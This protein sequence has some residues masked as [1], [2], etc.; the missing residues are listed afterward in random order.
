MEY[1]LCKKRVDYGVYF[2]IISTIITFFILIKYLSNN[3]YLF[4]ILAIALTILDEFDN[5]FL[6]TYKNNICSKSFYYQINDKMVDL[7]SYWLVFLFFCS[8][9]FF[10]V[11]LIYRT[12]GVLLFAFTKNSIWLI[13][14]PDILKEYLVYMF[15]YGSNNKYLPILILGKVLFEYYYHTFHNKRIYI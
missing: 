2:R 11:F 9:T 12:I 1:H 13:I 7:F 15:L 3:Q 6:I 8:N 14:M 4:I 10:L 5:L